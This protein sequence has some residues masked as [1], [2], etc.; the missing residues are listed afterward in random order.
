MCAKKEGPFELHEGEGVGQRKI[1]DRWEVLSPVTKEGDLLKGTGNRFWKLIRFEEPIRK[2][3]KC[4]KYTPV[5][6]VCH[7]KLSRA[8]GAQRFVNRGRGLCR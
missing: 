7:Q 3:K 5:E 4:R 6:M 1:K 8:Y 2:G